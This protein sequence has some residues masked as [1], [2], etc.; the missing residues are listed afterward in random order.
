MHVCV[1]ELHTSDPMTTSVPKCILH[2]H[3]HTQT[4]TRTHSD[5]VS[6]LLFPDMHINLM[7][8]CLAER[9]KEQYIMDKEI[10]WA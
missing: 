6:P 2:T 9:H 1:C 5:P 3:T 4:H 10:N 7:L 8:Y